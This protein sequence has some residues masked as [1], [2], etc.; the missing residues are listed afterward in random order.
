MKE[1]SVIKIKS[2][3]FALRVIK[4]YKYLVSEEKEYVMSKQILKSGT[5]IG[6][7]IAEAE[8]GQSKKDFVAKIYIAFK[9]ARESIYWLEL[10]RDSKYI[11]REHADSVMQDCNEL[12]KILCKIQKTCNKRDDV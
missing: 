10:L 2:K 9:E 7:N 8:A 11:K 3:N 5:S 1:E 12:C 4:L 6:A